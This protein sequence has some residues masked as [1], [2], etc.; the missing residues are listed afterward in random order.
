M[1]TPYTFPLHKVATND[2]RSD[3]S[4]AL[5]LAEQASN[6]ARF[7]DAELAE[8]G[9]N[10]D[11]FRYGLKTLEGISS[12]I[13][14]GPLTGINTVVSG[15][16]GA[17]KGGLLGAIIPALALG[18]TQKRVPSKENALLTTTAG[19]LLGGGFGLAQGA[20]MGDSARRTRTLL[21]SRGMTSPDQIN[22]ASS[23]VQEPER[24]RVLQTRKD[25]LGGLWTGFGGI[26]LA[27][28][29]ARTMQRR[30]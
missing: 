24:G 26:I 25:L 30:G 9:L 1:H 7:S 22:S 2:E 11:T 17:V 23:L 29:L 10:Q 19:T 27:D 4:A 5:Q 20:L 16:G 8:Y 13:P 6:A 14:D 21:A 18:I 28:F 3:L 15:V 12:V